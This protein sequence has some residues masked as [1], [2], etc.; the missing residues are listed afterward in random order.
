M[1]SSSK[2]LAAPFVLLGMSTAHAGPDPIAD[3]QLVIE[4]ALP[5]LI[6]PG[7]SGV[8]QMR[9]TN[10]GPDDSGFQFDNVFPSALSSLLLERPD[11]SLDIYFFPPD[12]PDECSF[13]V[14]V[15]DPRPPNFD[16]FWG[17][18][19]GFQ[20][21]L[22]NESVT[23]SIRYELNPS[24]VNQQVTMSWR[25]RTSFETDPNPNNNIAELV[26]NVGDG[27][28]S[29][30]RPVPSLSMI[31]LGLLVLAFLGFSSKAGNRR[32]ALFP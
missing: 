18:A 21:I 14:A 20:P 12:E 6:A 15:I 4:P 19:V 10:H 30:A 5:G 25:V 3:L 17:Y 9:V 7:E 28:V 1:A 16:V 23:C 29:P 24:I 8:L 31:G 2:I 26:F 11:G 27:A 32:R 13:R 22:V